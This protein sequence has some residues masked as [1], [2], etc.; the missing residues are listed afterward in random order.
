MDHLNTDEE[1]KDRWYSRRRRPRFVEVVPATDCSQFDDD[2][3]YEVV[4][5]VPYE[6]ISNPPSEWNLSSMLQTH[7]FLVISGV[8]VVEECTT[9][10]SLAWDWVKA[11]TVVEQA[12]AESLDA[13]QVQRLYDLLKTEKDSILSSRY[14]PRSVEGG[15]LNSGCYFS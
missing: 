4:R 8:L 13:S 7:G 10:L 15:R 14:F 11:A 2:G 6:W 9:A 3:Q 1:R 12:R 5:S